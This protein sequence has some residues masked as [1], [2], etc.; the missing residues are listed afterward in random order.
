MCNMHD[1]EGLISVCQYRTI[2]VEMQSSLCVKMRGKTNF[3]THTAAPLLLDHQITDV[4]VSSASLLDG[5][6]HL[7]GSQEKRK[8]ICGKSERLCT[9][10]RC[11]FFCTFP[12]ITEN[13]LWNYDAFEESHWASI[14]HKWAF[15]PG[16]SPSHSLVAKNL[17][18]KALLFAKVKQWGQASNP[19]RLKDSEREC[20]IFCLRST[21]PRVWPVCRPC[22]VVVKPWYTVMV[23]LM[24]L[25]MMTMITLMMIIPLWSLVGCKQKYYGTQWEKTKNETSS[26]KNSNCQQNLSEVKIYDFIIQIKYNLH[27]RSVLFKAY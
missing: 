23:R 3:E 18:E 1:R 13:S 2:C 9:F 7:C 17:G 10:W 11:M 27:T 12:R 5:C 21:K 6:W 16:L 19:E 22:A 14:E 8:Y 25:E 24:S 4:S 15:P 20:L 26:K